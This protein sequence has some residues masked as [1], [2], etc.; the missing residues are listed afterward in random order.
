MHLVK[1]LKKINFINY[2]SDIIEGIN[3]EF[4]K[5]HKSLVYIKLFKN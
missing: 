4:I 5:P 3:L 1:T 2:K